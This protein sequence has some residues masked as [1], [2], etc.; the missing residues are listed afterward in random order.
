MLIVPT[1]PAAAPPLLPAE[2]L[3]FLLLAAVS[4]VLFA[5]PLI[6]VARNLR[7]SKPDGGF[8]LRPIVPRFVR[9]LREVG[10]QSRVIR[11]RPL[12]GIAHAVV[13][14]AFCAFA[15]VT[16]NHLAWAEGL[17][18]LPRSSA[19]ARVIY[20]GAAYFAVAGSG[21]I[22][23]LFLRRFFL[24]PRWL[25]DK[26]SWESGL[27]AVLIFLLLTMHLV[28]CRVATASLAARGLWWVHTAI[29]LALVPLIPRTKH[30]HL[31]LAPVAI[32][33]RRGG[34]SHISPLEGD[35]DFG[36]VAG[37][38]VTRLAALQVFSCVECGRC[39]EHCP[40][41]ATS[42][43]LNPRDV[44]QNMRGYL[45]REGA[46]SEA[47]LL[48]AIL[49]E[50]ALFACITCG[51]C[52]AQ[53]PTGIEH[54]PLLI[55][56]RRGAV[57]TGKWHDAQGHRLFLQLER[58][59]NALGRPLHERQRLLAEL[60]LPLYDGSQEIC[61]WLGCMGAYDPKGREIVGSLVQLLRYQGK[62]V[63]VLRTESCCGDPVRRLGNDLLFEQLATANLERFQAVTPEL[64]LSICPHCVRTIEVDWKTFGTPPPIL[65]H[66]EYLA[67]H[68][69]K[70]EATRRKPG[71][72]VYHDP[73]YLSRYRGIQTEPRSV[74][75]LGGSMVEATRH[76]ERSFCCGAGGGRAFLGEESGTRIGHER[77]R[78]LLATGA[79]V[80]ATSCP[81]CHSMLD[82]A[83]ANM[84]SR[85]LALLD[86]AQIAA[87]QIP[88]QHHAHMEPCVGIQER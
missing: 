58:G 47:P 88:V 62:S 46:Q 7:A 28:S 87:A 71:K 11:H 59:T 86:I 27:I 32:F 77:A 69:R 40:A 45:R 41:V 50:E 63:G 65:H 68:L 85:P 38:D 70:F 6:A 4:A 21:G 8:S 52:E 39:M 78:E 61:L 10:L 55:G 1:I 80:V 67:A 22:T 12:P 60:D 76:G 23:L 14:W 57:N 82:D 49:S 13:F 29:L 31:L 33:L 54:L 48:E 34:F 30:L 73:C 5:G 84:Q 75:A 18:L 79:D 36:L 44:V 64:V 17:E 51:A 26:L 72:V 83:M 9:L 24:R 20:A 3:L 2:R 37:V 16:A 19:W 25:G 15:L 74:A 35:D 81:F 56:M 43:P 66:S 42:K 53:C